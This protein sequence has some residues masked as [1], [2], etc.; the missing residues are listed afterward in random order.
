MR[1]AKI[2]MNIII[3]NTADAALFSKCLKDYG[4]NYEMN[5][6]GKSPVIINLKFKRKRDCKKFMKTLNEIGYQVIKKN[7]FMQELKFMCI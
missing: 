1:R 3:E 2:D 6:I 5:F 4:E 7:D